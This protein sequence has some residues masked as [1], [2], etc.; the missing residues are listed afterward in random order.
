M[1]LPARAGPRRAPDRRGEPNAPRMR[2]RRISVGRRLASL[3][4]VEVVTALL[5]VVVGAVWLHR[6]DE[7][8][9]YLHR[10]V[11]PPI[12][13]L[14][15]AIERAGAIKGFLDAPRSIPVE[16]VHADVDRLEAFSARYRRT[17]RVE[18]N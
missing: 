4:V 15:V 17:W 18:D 1:D 3:V 5:L 11:L 10:W 12:D 7:E 14:G 8:M 16:Q 6:I 2:T 9:D 13:E